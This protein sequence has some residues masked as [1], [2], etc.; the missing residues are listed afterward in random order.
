MLRSLIESYDVYEDLLAK[1]K[2]GVSFY[3]NMNVSVNQL[4]DKARR[5]TVAEDEERQMTI[6]RYRPKG[7]Q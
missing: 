4:L 1:T 5:I 7:E 2:K 3:K 6:S